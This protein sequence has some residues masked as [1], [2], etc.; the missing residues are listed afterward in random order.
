M[1]VEPRAAGQDP[2]TPV[3]LKLFDA[4]ELVKRQ[5]RFVPGPVVSVVEEAQ[6]LLSASQL[7]QVLGQ[8]IALRVKGP[9]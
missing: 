9:A 6:K 1:A 7:N 2:A 5:D 8:R 4:A 3:L